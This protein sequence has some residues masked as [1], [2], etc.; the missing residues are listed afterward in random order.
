VV[1]RRRLYKCQEKRRSRC[2][3]KQHVGHGQYRYCGMALANEDG[4]VGGEAIAGSEETGK[5]A[6]KGVAKNSKERS[7]TVLVAIT[8][9]PAYTGETASASL[10]CKQGTPASRLAIIEYGAASGLTKPTVFNLDSR[11]VLAG[12]LADAISVFTRLLEPQINR[13]VSIE[14]SYIG[15][16]SAFL[17]E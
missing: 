7:T 17:F 13:Y 10:W 3:D 1:D 6:I 11:E 4:H 12:K 14:K 5:S 2:S 9:G 16:I 15:W 8:A